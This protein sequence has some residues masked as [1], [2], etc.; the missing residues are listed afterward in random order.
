M[1]DLNEIAELNELA[2]E[3]KERNRTIKILNKISISNEIGE[4]VYVRDLI[5]YLMDPSEPGDE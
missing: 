4:Y 3:L 5:E 1:N 2:G